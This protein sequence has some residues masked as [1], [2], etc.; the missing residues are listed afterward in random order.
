MQE[1]ITDNSNG[2]QVD[3]SRAIAIHDNRSGKILMVKL[4][5]FMCHQN[6][7]VEF[8]RRT[9][10]LIGNNGSGKSA[11][12]TALIIGLGCKANATNRSSNIKRKFL[13]FLQD[14]KNNR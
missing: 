2:L 10:L 5:N 1:N 8:N 9:N 14:K 11:V 3:R 4:R 6:L 13:S 12:L 7:V